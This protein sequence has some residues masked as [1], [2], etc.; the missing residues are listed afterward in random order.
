M[1]KKAIVARYGLRPPVLES[2]VIQFKGRVRARLGPI[3]TWVPVE[4][5]GRFL[6]PSAM[7]WDFMVKAVGVQIGSGIEAFD[8]QVYRTARGGKLPAA[9]DNPVAIRSMQ[10]RLWA[11]AAVMLTPLGEDFVRLEVAGEAMLQARNTRF[12]GAVCLNVRED[13]ALDHVE[14][15][16][17]NPDTDLQQVFR[18]QLSDDLRPFDDLILPAKINAFWDDDPYFELEPVHTEANP[19][20]PEAVFAL[21]AD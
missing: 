21:N 19:T 20:I 16:C 15:R 18:L 8:G 1:L 9:I 5:T 10:E 14:V 4:A 7:R 2:L 11:I 6:F 17:L 12:D 13:G 3:A